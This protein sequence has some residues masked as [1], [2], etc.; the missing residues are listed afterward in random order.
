M[1]HTKSAGRAVPRARA[2]VMVTL[3]GMAASLLAGAALA[4]EPMRLADASAA[5][6]QW[7]KAYEARDAEKLMAIFDRSLIYS[8]QG[9]GDQ[10]FE[11]L[12]ASYQSYFGSRM[13]PTRWKAIPKEIFAQGDMTVVI[14][15][16]EQRERTPSGVGEL[17][18]RTRSV[19]LFRR[20]KAG[21]KIVRT[22]SYPE[23]N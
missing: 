17:I 18:Q 20:T 8:A 15:I 11:E 16:W 1:N 9:E 4:A 21:W 3:I 22:I 5:Y 7:I 13:P 12:K 10:K 2:T 23:P 19:D 14:S 6:A